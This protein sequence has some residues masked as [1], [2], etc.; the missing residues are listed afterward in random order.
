MCKFCKD[1]KNK[2]EDI[3]VT[4]KDSDIDFGLL[5]KGKIVLEMNQFDGRRGMS[6]LIDLPQTDD[7]EGASIEINYCPMCGRKLGEV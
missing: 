7:T 5:G 6:A 4:L 3:F 1:F 2:D